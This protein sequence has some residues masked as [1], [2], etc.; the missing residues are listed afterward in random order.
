MSRE[1]LTHPLPRA[2]IRDE[3]GALLN[4]LKDVGQRDLHVRFGFAWAEQ[5]R[6]GWDE[7]VL[8]S[9]QLLPEIGRLEGTGAGR[10]GSDDLFIR[11]AALGLEFQFCND[12]DIHL[13]FDQPTDLTESFFASWQAQG[14]KPAEWLKEDGATP[15]RLRGDEP[16]K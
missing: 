10:L 3:L 14:F 15:R 4:K 5:F 6:A 16:S 12:S 1:I 2:V 13:R 11:V 9:T 7:I 8:P